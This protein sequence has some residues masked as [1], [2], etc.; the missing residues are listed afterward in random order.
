MSPSIV[1]KHEGKLVLKPKRRFNPHRNA[2]VIY[3]T[4]VNRHIIES[5]HFTHADN[6]QYYIIS[7][8]HTICEKVNICKYYFI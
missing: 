5:P 4:I 6:G 7:F 2:V 1:L 3:V 8:Y